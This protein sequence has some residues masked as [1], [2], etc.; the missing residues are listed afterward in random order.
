MRA[1][2]TVSRSSGPR[3]IAPD[4]LKSLLPATLSGG[5]RRTD[6]S[7]ASGGAAGFDFGNAKA[8]YAKGD[9]RITLSLTDM[10]AIGALAA[11]GSAF[12]AERQR[13]DRDLL[14]QDGPGRRPHDHGRVQ[15]GNRASANL[16]S[17]P[18][19]GSWWRP[20][21]PAPAWMRSN[22]Q[23]GRSISVKSKRSPNKSGIHALL[24]SR[25]STATSTLRA[26]RIA[27][28]QPFA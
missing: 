18:A 2:P 3:A 10:G 11:L 24:G 17:S 27:F 13:G 23:S 1:L 19:T 22:R 28:N 20:K 26:E 12:G 14:F 16:P 9:A 7:T 4:D 21:A 5:F 15:P 6:T 25:A 8:V